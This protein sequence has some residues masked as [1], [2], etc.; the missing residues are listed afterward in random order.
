MRLLLARLA[1]HQ[2]T[3]LGRVVTVVED[4]YPLISGAVE[5]VAHPRMGSRLGDARHVGVPR[6]YNMKEVTWICDVCDTA[7]ATGG[8]LPERTQ[9][10]RCCSERTDR[11][12]CLPSRWRCQ[13]CGVVNV[14]ALPTCL[15]CGVKRVLEHLH[16]RITCSSCF[17][18]TFLTEQEQCSKCGANLSSII[19]EAGTP[20]SLSG[21]SSLLAVFPPP[22]SPA[23][24]PAPRN[25]AVDN[26]SM[27]GRETVS[28]SS[29]TH[30]STLTAKQ[31]EGDQLYEARPSVEKRTNLELAL[32]GRVG[33][34]STSTST[35]T[36]VP[37]SFSSSMAGAVAAAR[38]SSLSSSNTGGINVSIGELEAMAVE[39]NEEEE[40]EE[41]DLEGTGWSIEI[42]S[43]MC[44]NC[45]TTNLEE[46]E[47]CVSCGI[48]RGDE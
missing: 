28:F 5:P 15:E 31:Y 45:E 43:W 6:E 39:E 36:S 7:V 42:P 25:C 4:G 1:V 12:L 9:C 16:T 37:S 24:G 34:T 21:L 23:D 8:A 2:I 38:M 11:S 20:I 32:G 26:N 30:D 14:Y 18:V 10:P 29:S 47:M 33:T 22:N 17:R 35:S 46:A 44:G 40:E 19:N 41:M 27:V 48:R 13:G 3:R